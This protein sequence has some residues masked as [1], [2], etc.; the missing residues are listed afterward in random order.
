M[1][2]SPFTRF[3]GLMP[4]ERLASLNVTIV[5]AGGIG[6]PTALALAKAGV[7]RLT[8]FDPDKVAEENQGTQLHPAN[9]LERRKVASVT[10]L[11]RQQCPWTEVTGY[12]TL[13][14]S[15]TPL[16]ADVVVAAVDSLSGR[17]EILLAAM[18]SGVSLLVDPRMG[19]EALNV[20]S[21]DLADKA[22]DDVSWYMPTLD[23]K[24]V[25]AAC[26]EKATFYTGLIAGGLA[27]Q[28][29][30]GWLRGERVRRY[31]M[32]LRNLLLMQ[33]RV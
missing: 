20:A 2:V 19:A 23:G 16:H 15:A 30:I 3:S 33:E 28:A 8:I 13:V 32:D 26:T 25:E 17:R 21:V 9:M 22:A 7:G 12:P 29:V 27:A 14:A 6:V 31:T 18:S 5:G 1:A 10:T 11:L 24:A 4:L